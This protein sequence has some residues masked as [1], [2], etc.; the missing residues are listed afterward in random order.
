[1]ES[2]LKDSANKSVRMIP[3]G[4][5]I[6]RQSIYLQE[7]TNCDASADAQGGTRK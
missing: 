2:V 1:M 7:F 6:Q 3:S 5:G 4:L